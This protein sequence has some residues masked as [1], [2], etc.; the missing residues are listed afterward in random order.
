MTPTKTIDQVSGTAQISTRATQDGTAKRIVKVVLA[1][2]VVA[3][4]RIP[5]RRPLAERA[6]GVAVLFHDVPA[7]ER[8]RFARQLEMFRSAGHVVRCSDLV[9]APDGVWRI[10]ITFDDGLLSY[11]LNAR[12]ELDRRSMSSTMFVITGLLGQLGDDPMPHEGMPTMRAEDVRALAASELHDVGSH[13]HRHLRLSLLHDDDV[14]EEL[15]RSKEALEQL[16]GAPVVSL[17][18]PYGDH[19]RKTSEIGVKMG[20]EQVFTVNPDLI[21]GSRHDPMAIGRIVVAPSDWKL[22]TWLKVRGGYRWV[23]RWSRFKAARAGLR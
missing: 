22:E 1:T 17:A 4:D 8:A 5:G 9:G 3:I 18:F 21:S 23:A 10:G 12:P 20:Y 19:R 15:G 6:R 16:L 13:T 11:E 14:V 7:A 2:S